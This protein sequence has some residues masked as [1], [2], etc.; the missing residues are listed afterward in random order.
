M[1]KKYVPPGS[2][3]KSNPKFS[4]PL[5]RGPKS[6][7]P[8]FTYQKPPDTSN[9]ELFPELGDK[10][11]GDET[12]S[13]STL[14]TNVGKWGTSITIGPEKPDTQR[15]TPKPVP[16]VESSS[17]NDSEIDPCRRVLDVDTRFALA[18]MLR[19]QREAEELNALN[20]YR[21]D[22][23]YLHELEELE[24]DRMLAAEYDSDYESDMSD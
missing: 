6:R 22:Y 13:M 20:G 2:K 10:K 11:A 3:A 16:T 24:H 23:V 8:A 14:P 19:R 5:G 4:R 17:A 18:T 7:G 1:T 12:G 9:E 21:D 15:P